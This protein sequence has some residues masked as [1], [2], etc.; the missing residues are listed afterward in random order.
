MDYQA[1]ARQL[2]ADSTDAEK[3]MWEQLRGRRF[4]GCK[5][6]RQVPVEPY[7]ADFVCFDLKLIVE[8]D[9]SQHRES[10]HYD[11]HRTRRL[12]SLGYHVV[13]YWDND[14]LCGLDAVMDALTQTLEQRERAS[15]RDR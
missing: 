6:R 12:E 11:E 15:H 2:R 9:G 13:R 14:V 1:R 8:I 10:R 7:I 3:R 4:H 5:F